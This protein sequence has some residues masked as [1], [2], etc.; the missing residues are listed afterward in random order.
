MSRTATKVK[1]AKKKATKA[2]KPTK[3]AKPTKP[4]K[5][6]KLRQDT[7]PAKLDREKATKRLGAIYRL[8]K[9][10][11]NKRV[12]H[13]IASSSKRIAKA[14]MEEAEEALAKEIREQRT[15]PG[16]LFDATQNGSDSDSSS[17]DTEKAKPS[18]QAVPTFTSA[19][20]VS[21]DSR[22]IVDN[23]EALPGMD[24]EC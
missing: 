20:R 3:S 23:G 9:T 24:D 8:E 21:D 22:V 4:T 16:P 2:A 19:S 12:A 1:P 15:G 18:S 7:D 6:A 5:P 11:E 10:L 13:S 17:S 14:E